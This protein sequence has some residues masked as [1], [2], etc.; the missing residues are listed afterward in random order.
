MRRTGFSLIEVVAVIAA[1]GVLV[2]VVLPGLQS[3][4]EASRRSRCADNCRL[5]GL[6]V[7]RYEAA[8]RAFPPGCDAFSADPRNVLPRL[9]AWSSFILPYLDGTPVP[10]TVDYEKGWNAPGG[11]DAASDAILPVYV[12]P[13]GIERFPGKQD[14]AGVHGTAVNRAGIDGP[15]ADW[16]HSGVLYST[17]D[18]AHRLPA[19]AAM[20][21]DGLGQT[22]L[23]AESVDRSYSTPEHPDG[24]TDSPIGASR[25]A[26]GYSCAHLS[27][28]VV[29]DPTVNSFASRHPG[30]I[31][32][33][34]ADG[35]VDFIVDD[36]DGD[37]LVA[38]CTRHGGEPVPKGF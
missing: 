33:V 27:S 17:N 21:S 4:R 12:C 14:Y 34:F 29:N 16:E 31:E 35:R 22:L 19:T 13:S 23:V 7:I 9:H 32:A 30:G 1:I 3:R 26:N 20:V 37:V 24:N 18:Q 15:V 8:R 5:M 10:V 28:R 38:I 2:A 6:G 25:W 11:N 36:V